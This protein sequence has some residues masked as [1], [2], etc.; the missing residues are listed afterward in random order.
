M[1]ST[2]K[3]SGFSILL[4][5]TLRFLAKL[6]LPKLD[7]EYHLAGLLKPVRIVR[8]DWGVPHI[9]AEN[10]SDL[11]FAQGFVHAQ[12]RLWQLE[13][14][15]RL[16]AGRLAEILG[17][18]ALPLDRWM[19]T[20]T[21]RRVADFEVNLQS[22][23]IKHHLQ[24]YADG[25]NTYL[26]KGKLPIEFFLLQHRPE[27][28]GIA[29]TLSWIKMMAWSLSV[30]WESEILRAH[31]VARLG[32]ELATELEPPQLPCWP[33]AIPPGA[34]Y[35]RV[36]SIALE[37]AAAARPF[38]GPSPYD[39][40][41]SNNWVIAG[42]KSLTGK[43]LLAND[44]HLG[45]TAPSIWYENHL[46]TKDFSITGVT[47]PG[48]PG[49]V[50]G[51]NG[52]VAWGYTNGFPD[53]QDIYLEHLKKL[54]DGSIEA[55]YNEQWEKIQVLHEQI[56]IKGH[57]PVTE[58]VLI[59]RHGPIINALS[60]DFCGEQP[61]ALRWTALEP[62][63]MIQALFSFIQA[64][65]CQQLHEALKLWTSPV[66]NVV[67]ADTLGNI[68]YTFAGKVPVR[69]KN[70]GRLP[71][72][73][74]TDEYEW[75]G[76][77]PFETLPHIENPDQGFIVTANNRVVSEDYPVQLD[78]EPISGDRA[79]RISEM[80]LD[81]GLR[82]GQEKID[83][84]FIQRMHFDQISPSAKVIIRQL[85]QLSLTNSAHYPETDL[86][87]AL[88][89]IKTWDGN[90]T[91]ES[92]AAAIYQ[93]FI[94]KFI[95]L[96][97]SNKLGPQSKGQ[98][99]Q[100]TSATEQSLSNTVLDDLTERV[101]GKGPTPILADSSLFGSHWLPWLVNLLDHPDSKWFDL[102]KGEKRDD[103]MRLALRMTIDELKSI[104]GD[105]MQEWSWGK[106]HQ[107]TF[108]HVLGSNRMLSSFLNLG[109]YP[110]GGDETTIWATSTSSQNLETDQMVGPPFRM[111]IDLKN[112]ENSVSILA[113]GQSG[114]PV[115]PY[116]K[117]QVKAWFEGAYHP[118]L[119]YP[120][121]VEKQA[122]HRLK[123]FPR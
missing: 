101:M 17:E 11:F 112:L 70:R 83:I 48:I 79:Q 113:P 27:P 47:F 58:E 41:G 7:G 59:T 14:S 56:N 89:Y 32:P 80:I 98:A 16:V 25:I 84:P 46:V 64:R 37:R 103:V 63:T 94:R 66:Q 69:A 119:Y 24:A 28:W 100:P 9:Y 39:G 52:H 108:Q 62:D 15:R 106:L 117:D 71:V 68:G 102:G 2:K 4:S 57:K 23:E 38:S 61:L 8:D 13:F 55:E 85:A 21:L 81:N 87:A 110:V 105:S 72:P 65:D 45:L 123:L 6:R 51:H 33:Y 60:P 18:I 95:W 34:E 31:L 74:W 12:D 78:L 42:S 121:E 90:L 36:G 26:R 116:Y 49:V 86:H 10:S 114:N 54:P 19:R 91:A 20:L 67:Y 44:M 77:L 115:S 73:G 96:V 99:D 22:V 53:V 30:N 88:K 40:L 93:V 118:I 82:N 35:Q 29:D 43:P 5:P 76:Y 50:S 111:I 92:T 122:K 3:G 109:P 104:S 75:T 107:V 1:K 97:L 120:P